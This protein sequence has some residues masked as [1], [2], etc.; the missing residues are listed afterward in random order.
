MKTESNFLTP[1]IEMAFNYLWP[2]FIK[3]LIFH[4]FDPEYNIWIET[5]ASSYIIS[6][7]LNQR[8]FGINPNWIVVET[9]LSQ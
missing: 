9:N 4:Y 5:D 8:T 6:R 7:V 2:A 3:A 1:N